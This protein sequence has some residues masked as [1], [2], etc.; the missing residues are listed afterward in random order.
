MEPKPAWWSE[1]AES[2]DAAVV[3][4]FGRALAEDR[5]ASGRLG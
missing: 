3:G 1:P 4:F 2:T 5:L